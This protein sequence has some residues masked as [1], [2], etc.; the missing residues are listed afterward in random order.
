MTLD[1]I[2]KRH[3]VGRWTEVVEG[4]KRIAIRQP[5]MT[6]SHFDPRTR[7][8]LAPVQHVAFDREDLG[9]LLDVLET[10]YDGGGTVVIGEP[11]A[12]EVMDTL[13]A[14]VALLWGVI[15]EIQGVLSDASHHNTTDMNHSWY[16]VL[17]E[18]MAKIQNAI[19]RADD[20]MEEDAEEPATADDY[21]H[22]EVERRYRARLKELGIDD[23]A[24]PKG[25]LHRSIEMLQ[26][27]MK[28]RMEAM[29]QEIAEGLLSETLGVNPL[30]DEQ[31]EEGTFTTNLEFPAEIEVTAND[32]TPWGTYSNK[33]LADLVAEKV[34]EKMYAQTTSGPAEGIDAYKFAQTIHDYTQSVMGGGGSAAV[35]TEDTPETE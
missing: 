22:E 34:V 9:E 21:D 35:N 25:L 20:A 31:W 11:S 2:Q 12:E 15:E 8:E 27:L 14:K 13:K 33:S 5:L 18:E 24:T 32:G 16:K 4:K 26:P 23:E 7:Q 3:E 1:I 28:K 10:I 17:F 30:Q 6:R 19:G 29:I